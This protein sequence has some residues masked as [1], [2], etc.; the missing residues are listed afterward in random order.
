[1]YH[2]PCTMYN[3]VTYLRFVEVPLLGSILP[4]Q[5]VRLGRSGLEVSLERMGHPTVPRNHQV[6]AM[7]TP[8]VDPTRW[9][10]L[11]YNPR[12]EV[13]VGSDLIPMSIYS[14]LNVKHGDRT[15]NSSESHADREMFSGAS[16]I[17]GGGNAYTS[18]GG[19][20][21]GDGRRQGALK[22]RAAFRDQT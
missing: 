3:Q 18:N 17:K 9:N 11:H 12:I 19:E 7:L 1:M 5:R 14:L 4:N 6:S 10:H 15:S 20:G 22:R 13:R 8:E 21:S 16:A 2:V